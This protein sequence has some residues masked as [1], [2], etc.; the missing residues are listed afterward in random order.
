[1]VQEIFVECEVSP[2]MFSDEVVVQVAGREY[3]VPKDRVRPNGQGRG[4]V[5]AKLVKDGDGEWVVLPTEYAETL[6]K[7]QVKITV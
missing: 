6:S 4:A 2:G 3:F 5:R 7:G 1:M